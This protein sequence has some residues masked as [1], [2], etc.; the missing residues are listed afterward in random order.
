MSTNSLSRRTF[1]ALSAMLP[2]AWSSNRVGKRNSSI[3]IGLEM[4]SVRDPLKQDAQGT[5][6]AVAQMGY[7][8]L[9]FYAPYYQ[10]TDEQAKD[11]RKL[12]D[13]LGIRCFSTHNDESYL[14]PDKISRTRDLNGILGTKYAVLASSLKEGSALDEW[15]GI[16]D[17]LNTAN[18]QLKTAGIH[19]GYHNHQPEFKK[20]DGK[21]PMEVLAANTHPEIMLQL[22]VGT[23][24][25]DGVDPVWWIKSN[26]GRIR[27]LHLKD[28]SPDQG[29]QVLFGDGV[30]KW[31]EIFA[32]AEGVGGAEYYLMEQ[33]GSRLG[34]MDTAKVCLNSYRKLRA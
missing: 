13:D 17:L 14:K 24:V 1:L 7:Q 27:S 11:M 19:A 21:Y 18:D 15:K 26:P 16:A 25:A 30:A 33:E 28:W 4:Y 31:P 12:L 20:V 3:P 9:E 5:V 29:Y 6:R 10:W 32:A 34:Q 2:V 8:G 23:C 22:D